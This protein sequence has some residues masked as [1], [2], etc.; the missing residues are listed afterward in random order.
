MLSLKQSYEVL[1]SPLLYRGENGSKY[2]DLFFSHIQSQDSNPRIYLPTIMLYQIFLIQLSIK[3]VLLWLLYD[4]CVHL[5]NTAMSQTVVCSAY[6]FQ[7]PFSPVVPLFQYFERFFSCFIWKAECREKEGKQKGKRKIRDW[8]CEFH[9]PIGY[10]SQ[11]WARPK[12]GARP[13]VSQGLLPERAH[14][15]LTAIDQSL[16]MHLTP[17]EKHV[18][19]LLVWRLWAQLIYLWI[20]VKKY[21]FM[22]YMLTTYCYVSYFIS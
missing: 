2:T 12:P 10:N 16:Y 11:E 9:L 3:K 8:P 1:L 22:Q 18:Y 5:N 6:V 17:A 4:T 21:W 15:C 19:L 14:I 20:Y 13:S 7:L